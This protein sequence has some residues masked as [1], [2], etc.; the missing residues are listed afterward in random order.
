MKVAENG[1]CRGISSAYGGVLSALE[2]VYTLTPPGD[3]EID[4]TLPTISSRKKSTKGEERPAKL[5][6]RE[7]VRAIY[8]GRSEVLVKREMSIDVPDA[9]K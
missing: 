8:E 4:E 6:E 2:I 1:I 5:V 7:T 3:S 9:L